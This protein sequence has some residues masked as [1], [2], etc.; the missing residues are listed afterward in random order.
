MIP[1]SIRDRLGMLPDDHVVVEQQAAFVAGQ[2][3]L[4][5]AWALLVVVVGAR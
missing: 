2:A 3:D 5:G 1:R 4:G